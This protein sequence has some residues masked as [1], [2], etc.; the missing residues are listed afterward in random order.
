LIHIGNGGTMKNWLVGI[1]VVLL[2]FLNGSTPSLMQ[3]AKLQHEIEQLAHRGYTFR[4]LS[5][6]MVELTNALTGTKQMRSLSPPSEETIRSWAAQRGIPIIEIDPRLIDTSLYA[7]LYKYWDTVPLS[8]T[9]GV[10]LVIG[11]VD[12]NANPE[13]YGIYIGIQVQ[14]QE[15]E[16]TR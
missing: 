1:G 8:N 5:T 6:D 9:S 14:H 11:D 13:I 3:N 16:S 10:P 7:G 2:L 4:F 12:G 15:A